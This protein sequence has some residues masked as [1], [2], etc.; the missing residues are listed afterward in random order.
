[1]KTRLIFFLVLSLAAISC[2]KLPTEIAPPQNQ[3]QIIYSASNPE[4]I[5]DSRLAMFIG[6]S[7]QK[8]SY[9]GS[10]IYE[11][12]AFTG[13]NGKRLAPPD[14]QYHKG[15]LSVS[16]DKSKLV[17][18]GALYGRYFSHNQIFILDRTTGKT[19][20]VTNESHNEK[21]LFSPDGNQIIFDSGYK[22]DDGD[23]QKTF[24]QNIDGTGRHP[25]YPTPRIGDGDGHFLPDGKHVV[26]VSN[27][28]M[29]ETPGAEFGQVYLMQTDGSSPINLDIGKAGSSRPRPSPDGRELFL[30]SLT[31]SPGHPI[32]LKLLD[33]SSIL[34][35]NSFTYIDVPVAL[36]KLVRLIWSP[37]GQRVALLAS[38]DWRETSKF[39]LYVMKK[40]GSELMRLTKNMEVRDPDWSPDSKYIAFS[41][42]KDYIIDENPA[43]YLSEVATASIKTIRL[44]LLPLLSH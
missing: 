15:S 41:N 42:S 35:D 24:I 4:W 11:F 44:K 8:E 30:Y 26:L 7:G 28:T 2:S 19:T 40:N 6:R 34:L 27:L 12:D 25:V 18:N 38:E 29:G 23:V 37:D 9:E 43:I 5:S 36:S 10:I 31:E 3:P 22:F 17:Y 1:M 39:D 13:E 14:S 20:Q 16:P 33:I 21:P 32:G